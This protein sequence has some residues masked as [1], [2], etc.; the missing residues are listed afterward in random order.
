MTDWFKQNP[1]TGGLVAVTLLLALAGLYF[2][3]AQSAAFVEQT[4]AFNAN[5]SSLQQ[6][7]SAKPFPDEA[8]LRAAEAEAVK[9]AE[10]LDGLASE[11]A[12]QAAASD[13]GLTPRDFQDKLSSA[14]AAAE[15]MAAARKV[16]LPDEFYLGFSE[17]KA[18]PPSE[19]AAP[20]LGPQL[21]TIANV[22]KLLLE[23]GVKELV[24][25]ERAPLAS[26]SEQRETDAQPGE[27][28][29]T[30]LRLDPFDVDFVADPV[31]FRTAL[32]AIVASRPIVMV[33]LV[34]VANS[35]P[36]PP[37]KD[38]AAAGQ[39]G[40]EP[41]AEGESTTEIPVV[42]GK[43]TLSVKLRLASVSPPAAAAKD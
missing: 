25:I 42:F 36:T 2:A 34:S 13:P 26:E 3:H 7:Q 21:E 31:A 5:T 19:E 1:F 41:P 35:S 22:T 11:V 33:R 16:S 43:E 15:E 23:S 40:A 4:D 12:G 17:Y 29:G 20:M 18:Q 8:N 14:A 30:A 6:L 38:S 37:A 10:I 9:A 27:S 32:S 39:E 24:A 28:S